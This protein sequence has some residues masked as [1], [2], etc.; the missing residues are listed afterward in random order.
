MAAHW[1]REDRPVDALALMVAADQIR[2]RYGHGGRWYGRAL[3]D[4]VRAEAHQ[5]LD[6]RQQRDARRRASVL[7]SASLSTVARHGLPADA[8]DVGPA[9]STPSTAYT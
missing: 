7:D 3:A 6:D 9:P 8:Y 1:V 2:T 5:Q 4:R